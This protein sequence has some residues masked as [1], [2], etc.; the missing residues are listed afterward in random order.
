M[1][2]TLQDVHEGFFKLFQPKVTVSLGTVPLDISVVYARHSNREYAKKLEE[3]YPRIVL[4]DKTISFSS[5][6]RP[7]EEKTI[8]A[9]E[10]DPEGKV[11]GAHLGKDPI[12]LVF[13]YQVSGYFD[14]LLHKLA[15][16]QWVFENFRA[17]GGLL[18][19]PIEVEGELVG[20]KVTYSMYTDEFER[21]DGIFEYTLFF[22]LRP[23]VHLE[24]V[25]LLDLVETHNININLKN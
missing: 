7:N 24:K 3:A 23:L 13:E 5:D 17:F 14:N 8:L 19:N 15:F 20:D 22:T 11:I 6:W 10:Y 25:E 1:L 18:F 9:Y 21:T 2:L 16:M 12:E 4:L